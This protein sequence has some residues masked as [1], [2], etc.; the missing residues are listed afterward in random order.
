M[1]FCENTLDV[2]HHEVFRTYHLNYLKIVLKKIISLIILTATARKTERLAAWA[3]GHHVN[4]SV[5][6]LLF[7]IFNERVRHNIFG[8]EGCFEAELLVISNTMSEFAVCVYVTCK[9]KIVVF[10]I[11]VGL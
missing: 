3:A 7:E 5:P 9:N 10:V 6:D 2:F 4:L 8:Q 1:V 11:S